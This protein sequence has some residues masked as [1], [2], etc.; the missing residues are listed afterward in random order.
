MMIY[1]ASDSKF[2]VRCVESSGLP[3]VVGKIYKAKERAD[4]NE[5]EFI[6]AEPLS[7]GGVNYDCAVLKYDDVRWKFE[8][9]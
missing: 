3:F 6:L 8:R 7:G 4:P 1:T 2:E 9:I 5:N